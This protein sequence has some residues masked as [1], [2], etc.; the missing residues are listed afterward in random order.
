MGMFSFVKR[1]L[2]REAPQPD[3]G[4]RQPVASTSSQLQRSS[5][6]VKTRKRN[7]KG[8]FTV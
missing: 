6:G 5:G 2:S 8:Q 3:K 1:V 7:S 4:V